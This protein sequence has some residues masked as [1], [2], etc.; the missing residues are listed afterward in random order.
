L[1]QHG[2]LIAVGD[3]KKKGREGKGRKGKERKGKERKGKVGLSHKGLYFSNEE[4]T[5][6]DRFPRK[7]ARFK[8]PMT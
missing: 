7:L 5:T 3:E 6:L 8:G 1:R 2:F 4:Q